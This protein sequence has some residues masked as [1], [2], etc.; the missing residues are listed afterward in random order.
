MLWQLIVCQAKTMATI[1]PID[2]LV[3]LKRQ[4]EHAMA[5][6]PFISPTEYQQMDHRGVCENGEL[7]EAT[8]DYLRV[9]H[10]INNARAERQG[11]AVT[12]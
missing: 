12:A 10:R 4:Y 2:R 5:F 6:G 11:K 7:L 3:E 1:L 8:L 9:V